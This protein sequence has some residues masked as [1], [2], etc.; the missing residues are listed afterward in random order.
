M[1]AC[2][3]T[4]QKWLSRSYKWNSQKT[5]RNLPGRGE[6]TRIKQTQLYC[7]KPFCSSSSAVAPS[8]LQTHGV[9]RLTSPP[10]LLQQASCPT[11]S[12]QLRATKKVARLQTLVR[13]GLARRRHEGRWVPP[14]TPPVNLPPAWIE[15][16]SCSLGTE[17]PPPLLT[18]QPG[19]EGKV[20]R[21]KEGS[22]SA[23]GPPPHP[24]PPPS[25]PTLSPPP[26]PRG[27]APSSRGCSSGQVGAS[28]RG[29]RDL[30]SAA[31]GSAAGAG[32]GTIADGVGY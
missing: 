15:L 14:G 30:V 31:A 28:R 22:R 6:E 20:E 27:P 32:T 18:M 26:G 17:Q 29:R 3:E 5:P 25:P 1:G 9:W 16:G 2:L 12:R 11:P 8:C 4:Q 21:W 23:A 10:P 24:T 7:L 13:V 19:P